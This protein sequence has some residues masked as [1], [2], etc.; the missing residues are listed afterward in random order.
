MTID[1]VSAGELARAT[2]SARIE[3]PQRVV[4]AGLG[5]HCEYAP[6][7]TLIQAGQPPTDVFLALAGYVKVIADSP[8]G[9][10]SLIAIRQAGDLLGEISV[11]DR[12]PRSATVIA[13][14]A[15]QLRVVPPADFAAFRRDYP[16][17]EPTLHSYVLAKFRQTTLLR[18]VTGRASVR[19]RLVEILLYLATGFGLTEQGST[20]IPFPLSQEELAAFVGAAEV[21]VH[22]ELTR[23]RH[24][25]VV[26][27]NYREIVIADLGAL[28]ELA[29][30]G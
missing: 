23:L 13:L 30:D 26:R 5:R 17:F 8:D 22:R 3:W 1:G 20:V 25:A 27:T 11:M 4:P 29:L 28:K 12:R 9:R 18:T 24:D 21:S 16:R 2:F 14:T 10:T 7:D 6:Y 19:H 15:I